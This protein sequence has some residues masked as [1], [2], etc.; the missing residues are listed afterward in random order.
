MIAEL[1]TVAGTGSL[2]VWQIDLAVLNA[3][4]SL[5]TFTASIWTDVGGLPGVQVP[6]A[7]WNASTPYVVGTCCSLVSI[8]GITNVTLTGGSQYFLTLAPVNLS[9]SGLNV[10]AYNSVGATATYLDSVDGAASWIV[11]PNQPATAFDVLSTPEPTTTALLGLGFIAVMI[12]R[13]R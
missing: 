9:D 4:S 5:P 10:W 7:F 1:F 11:E 2:P 8:Q 3:N 6:G 13:R 12:S